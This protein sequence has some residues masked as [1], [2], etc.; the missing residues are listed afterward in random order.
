MSDMIG[1]MPG[2]VAEAA[3]C[4][5][6]RSQIG[7]RHTGC[8]VSEARSDRLV[9]QQI[10]KMECGSRFR[11]S[12]CSFWQIQTHV[13]CQPF[14]WGRDLNGY[15][16]CMKVLVTAHAPWCAGCSYWWVP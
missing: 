5:G 16:L 10:P 4:G 2:Y 14:A 1:R 12:L 3:I 6:N 15:D 7:A 8:E 11:N 13:I 9:P